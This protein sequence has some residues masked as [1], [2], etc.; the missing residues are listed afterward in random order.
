MTHGMIKRI[1]V[2]VGYISWKHI[3]FIHKFLTDTGWDLSIVDDIEC[4]GIT[5]GILGV[6]SLPGVLEP[7]VLLIVKE[8]TTVGAVYPPHVVHK[9]KSICMLSNDEPDCTLIPCSK[10]KYKI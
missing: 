8:A 10:H 5:P 7:P 2:F 6:I 9:I 3:Y 1:V 4:L